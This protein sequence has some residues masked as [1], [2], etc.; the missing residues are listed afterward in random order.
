MK[1][2]YI[3][4]VCITML[5][6]MSS[7]FPTDSEYVYQ[8]QDSIP[9]TITPIFYKGADISWVTEMEANNYNFYDSNGK[10]TDIFVLLK[11]YQ[12]NTIRLRVWVHPNGGWNGINDVLVKAK[13]AAANGFYI[14]IDFHYSDW[15]ADPGK[16][17]K[18]ATWANVPFAQ[19]KD[20]LRMHTI[21]T[22]T[23]LKNNNI[24]PFMVQI[25]NELDNGLLWP[26]GK[27]SVNMNQFAQ[28][29]TTGYDATKLVFP[30]AVV[31]VHVSNGY[32]NDLFRWIFDGLKSNNGKWDAIGMSLYP[33]ID[34]K[35]TNTW[36]TY[37]AQCL[38]NMNDMV[39]RYNS[40]VYVVEIGSPFDLPE[41]GYNFITD[42]L[43]KIKLVNNN[44]G[45]GIMFWEPECYNWMNYKLGAFDSQGKPTKAM[46]GFKD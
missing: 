12:I 30:N 9:K 41:I 4:F 34:S 44:K 43:K 10:Q 7:C 26:D 3:L 6:F 24:T 25:G 8:K 17:T 2:G 28:L 16:Q 19:L 11:Q 5:P 46:N 37:N 27:A 29:I 22:L 45:R 31:M 13:R 1:F 32:N 14:L 40:D 35:Q 21:E 20:S 39:N 38:A 33:P 23:A 36:Q 18:P 15:W 42:L